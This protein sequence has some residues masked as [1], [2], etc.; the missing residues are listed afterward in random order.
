MVLEDEKVFAFGS[1]PEPDVGKGWHGFVGYTTL[2]TV[3]WKP[4][5]AMIWMMWKGEG[6]R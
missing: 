6:E 1:I 3:C 2:A 4:I 5:R